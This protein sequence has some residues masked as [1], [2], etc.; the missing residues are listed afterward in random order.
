MEGIHQHTEIGADLRGEFQHLGQAIDEA[1]A[2]L[3]AQMSGPDEFQTESARRSATAPR[4]FAAQ[5]RV[6]AGGVGK[7]GIS[8]VQQR[9]APSPAATRSIS[10]RP[11]MSRWKASSPPSQATGRKKEAIRVRA[12]APDA[13]ALQTSPSRPGAGS[14]LGRALS[15]D[16]LGAGPAPDISQSGGPVPRWRR[17]A[18]SRAPSSP[19]IRTGRRF[20]NP[21][22]PFRAGG[23]G[24]Y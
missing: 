7:F 5:S 22:L 10:L 24:R 19:P 20:G 9:V 17:S 12:S 3:L 16:S 18:R 6:S 14:A 8:Q 23:A 15:S 1:V 2:G 11:A 4:R 21:H 13:L